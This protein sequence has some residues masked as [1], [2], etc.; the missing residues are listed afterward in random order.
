VP[1]PSTTRHHLIFKALEELG[2]AAEPVLYSEQTEEAVRTRL[3]AMDGV[4]VWVAPLSSGKDRTRLALLR[5]IAA[6]GVWV[7][8]HPDVILKMG[9]K[10]VLYR[11]RM[12]GWGT[13][14]D[15][16]VRILTKKTTHSDA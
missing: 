2:V 10:E 16:Y 12:L 5:D 9:V 7:S 11:T 13:D 6:Q 3:L 14:T 15:L 8:A 1:S 4:L